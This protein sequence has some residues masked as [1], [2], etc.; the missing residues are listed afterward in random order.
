MEE[1]VPGHREALPEQ[2]S[3]EPLRP[4][5]GCV[6]PRDLHRRRQP[7]EAPLREPQGALRP[8]PGLRGQDRGLRGSGR[9]N[10]GRKRRRNFG[11][12]SEDQYR[13]LRLER[14]SSLVA[15]ALPRRQAR[16]MLWPRGSCRHLQ[17]RRERTSDSENGAENSRTQTRKKGVMGWQRHDRSWHLPAFVARLPSIS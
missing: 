16:L 6:R 5:L 10:P 17:Q 3:E 2:R 9:T 4:R 13:P 14:N 8:S 11:G 7:L 12:T 1:P 15:R